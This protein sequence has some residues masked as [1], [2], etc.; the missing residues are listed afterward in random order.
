M[1]IQILL[2]YSSYNTPEVGANIATVYYS[3]E[4]EL[5]N[6]VNV[7]RRY[8]HGRGGEGRGKGGTVSVKEALRSWEGG[9]REGGEG[10]GR[11]SIR[12]RKYLMLV[13]QRME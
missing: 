6:R 10:K 5:S 12:K 9:G 13:D 1:R 8:G 3:N 11:Y 2:K 4:R 7:K